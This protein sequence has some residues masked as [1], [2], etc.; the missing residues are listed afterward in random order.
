MARPGLT[1]RGALAA[2]AAAVSTPAA[3]QLRYV[4]EAEIAAVAAEAA[5]P[6]DG[7]ARVL[8]L[9]NSFTFEH[10]VPERVAVK[11]ADDGVALRPLML[12]QGG[13]RLSQLKGR[14]GMRALLSGHDWDA[15]VAQDHSTTALDPGFRRENEAA[16]ACIAG[17]VDPAP[18][19]IVTPWAREEE[20]PLYAS[21][22]GLRADVPPPA[23]PRAM[24]EATAAHFGRVADDLAGQYRVG[25]APVATAW[26]AA[27]EA[28]R[29][30]HRRDRYHASEEGADFTAGIVWDALALLLGQRPTRAAV[31]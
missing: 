26:L 24:T 14:P 5:S 15:V 28:G 20:H 4:T 23:D 22:R 19:V 2:L 18:L 10:D 31:Q 13:A 21:G 6:A 25:L 17:L 29:R 27:I 9:G 8:F 11:A 3:A 16:L 30:L 1:R 7:Q 12:A